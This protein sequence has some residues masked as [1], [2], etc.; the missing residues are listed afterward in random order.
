[1][2]DYHKLLARED[3]GA[4][5]NYDFDP[6]VA[7]HMQNTVL[8]EH[9]EPAVS[10][11]NTRDLENPLSFTGVP[12]GSHSDSN[13]M[14]NAPKMMVVKRYVIVDTAQRD[15][16]RYPNPY[17][18]VIFTFG[19]QGD[20]QKQVPVYTNNT[21][22]PTFALPP[23]YNVSFTPLPGSSNTRG[24][25]YID[26]NT[27]IQ[28]D[29]SAYNSSIPRGNF[30]AYDTPP[31][32]VNSGDYFGTPNTPSN[33]ISI[34]LVRAILPQTP[35][36][37]YPADPLFTTTASETK[38]AV[39]ATAYNTFGTYP[40]LLFYLN[41]YRGQ[42]YAP[43][44][45]G[46]RAFTVLTQCNRAQI[47]FGLA[48][49][50]QYF[51]YIPWNGE[52][53]EF[54]S[55]LTSLQ[56]IAITVA[57]PHGVPF[58][59]NQPDDLAIDNI[60][61]ATTVSG[62]VSRATLLCVTPAYKTYPKSQLRVGDRVS[63][64]TPYLRLIEKGSAIGSNLDKKSFLNSLIDQTFPVLDVQIYAF[65][66]LTNTYIPASNVPTST[67]SVID[68]FN[69]FFIPNFTKRLNTGVLV[70]LYPGAVDSDNSILNIQS[71]LGTGNSLPVLNVTQQPIYSFELV[72]KIPDTTEIGGT[73]VN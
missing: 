44:E 46:C 60:L 35:F 28:Y 22:Y 71:L 43:T 9:M 56:K 5:Q 65:D 17:S 38:N 27:G 26:S 40:Y 39:S 30:V 59:L 42:Y 32:A 19:G 73:V 10:V 50:T 37:S 25:S 11:G 58:A 34:R 62:G 36:V 31:N 16:T 15:W 29:L 47:N 1:M 48:N 7:Y 49:G 61:L 53:I 45:A 41:E 3:A 70:D 67:D 13:M 69:V 8:R 24:F 12:E 54:Q 64:Y 21:T 68:F 2:S 20:T 52:G 57:D 23:T 55:P 51:D 72:H 14:Q 33:V 66:P 4:R 18:N 63:F 6:R